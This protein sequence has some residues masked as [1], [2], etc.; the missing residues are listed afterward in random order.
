VIDSDGSADSA[1]AKVQELQAVV[2]GLWEYF[3]R[4]RQ[5][6]D[7]V[8]RGSG[9][10]ALTSKE[11]AAAAKVPG[12]TFNGWL[13]RQDVVPD[14]EQFSELVNVVGG[15]LAQAKPRWHRAA[16][17]YEQLRTQR[18]RRGRSRTTTGESGAPS[19]TGRRR[20][21]KAWQVAV[22]VAVLSAALTAGVFTFLTSR[23]TTADAGRTWSARI[24][25]TWS[26]KQQQYLG[27]FGYK[28]PNSSERSGTGYGE[29]DAISV[30]CQNRHGRTI[31]DRTSGQSSDVWDLLADGS[32]IS[33]LYT[34]LTKTTDDIP[35]EGMP[36][37]TH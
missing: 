36:T 37:C 20:R 1:A 35:P 17:A 3:G 6:Y 34:T 23:A 4:L 24:I 11:I 31:M 13:A 10:K 28:S 14:W 9:E 15:D 29:S 33:D 27:T 30:L 25:N 19:T 16:A 7:E 5:A 12:S 32:W 26:G 22:V 18:T 2:R 8:R 21:L